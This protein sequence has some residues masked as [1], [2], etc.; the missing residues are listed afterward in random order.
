MSTCLL[1]TKC[2]LY[3]ISSVRNSFSQPTTRVSVL[4]RYES[5]GCLHSVSMSA[6]TPPVC[7]TIR[8]LKKSLRSTSLGS[9]TYAS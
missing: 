7:S 5:I 1:R 2:L 4:R 8:Y 9:D 3:A 6:Y